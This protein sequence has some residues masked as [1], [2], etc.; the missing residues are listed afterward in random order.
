MHFLH[1]SEHK[2]RTPRAPFG[3]H[4]FKE[5][6]SNFSTISED[7]FLQF[8][9]SFSANFSLYEQLGHVQIRQLASLSLKSSVL[10][11]YAAASVNGDSQ[12]VRC[13]LQYICDCAGFTMPSCYR[14]HF[15]STCW[16]GFVGMQKFDFAS[17]LSRHWYWLTRAVSLCRKAKVRRS[18]RSSSLSSLSLTMNPVE[19]TRHQATGNLQWSR[20]DKEEIFP[21]C[22]LIIIYFLLVK[23][24]KFFFLYIAS[25]QLW[26]I[27]ILITRNRVSASLPSFRRGRVSLFQNSRP[28]KNYRQAVERENDDVEFRHTRSLLCALSTSLC[29]QS[30]NQS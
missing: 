23:L 1:F 13:C 20:N 2:D 25:L 12:P 4:I 19:S 6:T 24:I 17:C 11:R 14:F 30:I 8:C 9:F 27:K 28:R 7:I 18:L 21:T 22:C 29:H 16:A 15:R 26:W 5:Q 3:D 10:S